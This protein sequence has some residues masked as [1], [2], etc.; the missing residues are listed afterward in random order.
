MD[1]LHTSNTSNLT[2]EN[3]NNS[4]LQIVVSQHIDK[5]VNNFV[6]EYPE[7]SITNVI[8]HLINKLD[9]DSFIIYL[10]L[11]IWEFSDSKPPWLQ[12]EDII[13]ISILGQL[14]YETY[15][16]FLNMPDIYDYQNDIL[17]KFS[18]A[19]IQLAT[20]WMTS[21]LMKEMTRCIYKW[22][23]KEMSKEVKNNLMELGYYFQSRI[24]SQ[25]YQMDSF[26]K[27][28]NDIQSRRTQIKTI[29]EKW[30]RY[31]YSELLYF[32]FCLFVSKKKTNI[33]YYRQLLDNID[34]ESY[35]LLITQPKKKR[36]KHDTVYYR[37][38]IIDKM[39]KIYAEMC[40]HYRK[41]VDIGIPFQ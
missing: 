28:D 10:S 26:G 36:K 11:Q 31:F 25:Q 34:I 23:S 41:K 24:I 27:L 15:M 30:D 18:L 39:M 1:I 20:I 16:M 6:K 7:S 5:L 32:Y 33:K 8:N 4:D 3:N 21:Y 19:Q 22:Q 29:I 17:K 13:D 37:N 9:H 2:T 40:S 35:Y 14:S 12:L 38:R